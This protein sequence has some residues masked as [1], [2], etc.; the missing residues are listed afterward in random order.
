MPAIGVDI[1]YPR[2][3][4]VFPDSVITRAHYARFLTER[5]YTGS[6]K[7]VFPAGFAGQLLPESAA[8]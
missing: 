7:G 2:L 1:T 4:E 8:A 6:M 3:K 5:G